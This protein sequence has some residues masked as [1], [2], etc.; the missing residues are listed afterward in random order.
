MEFLD[1]L[2][3]M[4][5]VLNIEE[6]EKFVMRLWVVWH[7]RMRVLH[8]KREVIENLDVN[9]SE[10]YLR[11]FQNA[12]AA[13]KIS[14]EHR[15]T[16]Y[17]SNYSN[18]MSTDLRLEVDAAV[19]EDKDR[20]GI[21]GVVRNEEGNIVLAFGR[22]TKKPQSVLYEELLAIKE[23][24]KLSSERNVDVKIVCSDSLLAVQAVINPEEDFS[25]NGAIASEIKNFLMRGNNVKIVHIRRSQNLVAHNLASF[26]ISSQDPF[27]WYNGSF[28]SWLVNLVMDNVY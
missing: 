20:C 18:F 3:W 23:G 11:E 17:S 28:P 21:G 2:M 10:T 24:L 8:S 25:Y 1:A 15:N 13:L 14:H 12:N 26:A 4:R 27:V 16:D 5:R 19:N 22:Q 6:F 7:E 9:W